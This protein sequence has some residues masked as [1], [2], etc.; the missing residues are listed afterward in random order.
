MSTSIK[1]TSNITN[2]GPT[3]MLASVMA[4]TSACDS[5]SGPNSS[6]EVLPSTIQQAELEPG[7]LYSLAIP[8]SYTGDEPVPLVLALH[9]GGH[10]QPYFGLGVLTGLV[11]PALRDLEAI[12]VSPDCTG[13]DWTD[14]QSEADVLAVLDHVEANFNIDTRWTAV[15]GYSM[16]G[17]GTW[18]LANL[19]PDRFAAAIVVSGS[20]PTGVPDENWQVPLYVIHSSLDR[21]LP[22]IPTHLAVGDLL[23]R[24]VTVEFV[25]IDGV[26][27][28]DTDQFIQPLRTAV[29]WIED[30][31]L[32]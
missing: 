29:P 18:H 11:E 28:Y 32:R 24:G 23:D 14:P 10:G 25:I 1:R 13:Q 16:G 26:T 30:I 8:E 22:I 21:V 4:L 7:R 6:N 2:F 5:S 19:H 27:H 20:P 9:Y 31:W 15:T 17:I 12:I 3:L